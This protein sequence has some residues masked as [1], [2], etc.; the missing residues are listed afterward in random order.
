MQASW[1]VLGGIH[2]MA[3]LP[4]EYWLTSTLFVV[5]LLFI[6]SLFFVMPTPHS[7]VRLVTQPQAP[8]P[9]LPAWWRWFYY[10]NPLAYSLYAISG[11]YEQ[12]S[13]SSRAVPAPGLPPT[14]L[15]TATATQA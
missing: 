11:T 15:G 7:A 6:C 9:T 14:R 1:C 5:C 4:A 2:V 13:C 10:S 8:L 12:G 3:G